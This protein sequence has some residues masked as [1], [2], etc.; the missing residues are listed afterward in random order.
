MELFAFILT[1]LQTTFLSSQVYAYNRELV[2][3]NTTNRIWLFVTDITLSNF[4]F[5]PLI[6]LS[7][8]GLGFYFT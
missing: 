4:A 2:D 7:N 5:A 3:G 8:T 6:M 1:A